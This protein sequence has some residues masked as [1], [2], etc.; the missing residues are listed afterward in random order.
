[1]HPSWGYRLLERW[2]DQE[3]ALAHSAH[4]TR[5]TR[6]RL[7]PGPH[8][9]TELTTDLADETD[10]L[11]GP[12]IEIPADASSAFI[13]VAAW[14]VRR[15]AELAV[16]PGAVFRMRE[17]RDA[18]ARV[19][20][21]S[22]PRRADLD[23]A[24]TLARPEDADAIVR[25]ELA[26]LIWLGVLGADDVE[27]IRR[28]GLHAVDELVAIA[29]HLRNTANSPTRTTDR[30]ITHPNPR[31]ATPLPD[32]ARERAGWL[33]AT[34]P[35]L[36]P[37]VADIRRDPHRLAEALDALAAADDLGQ[38]LDDLRE[39]CATTDQPASTDQHHMSR[40]GS[41][42]DSIGLTFSRS[43]ILS[44]WSRTF[45]Y[46]RVPSA[47]EVPVFTCALLLRLLGPSEMLST[48]GRFL[49]GE[50]AIEQVMEPFAEARSV[51]EALAAD[52]QASDETP[53]WQR[54]SSPPRPPLDWTKVVTRYW[55]GSPEHR[56]PARAESEKCGLYVL[57]RLAV[58]WTSDFDHFGLNDQMAGRAQANA[59]HLML[60]FSA[61]S[62]IAAQLVDDPGA[63][64]PLRLWVDE[65]TK[66][67]LDLHPSRRMGDG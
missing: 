19:A 36:F 10:H 54:P 25:P 40:A 60:W 27:V 56:T 26:G 63:A 3:H 58:T 23:V 17:E 8:A 45:A 7:V 41:A 14:S 5:G 50:I 13:Q 43:S 30:P 55:T 38:A 28:E 44:F 35:F 21:L 9:T 48:I 16:G 64:A 39:Q 61:P 4:G 47:L 66:F 32:W 46:R 62:R 57:D 24:T 51:V 37:S 11:P 65:V 52:E 22:E 67:L 31:G 12:S 34:I 49:N 29:H 6:I 18:F 20:R 59:H 33:E 42:A 2:R 53:R 15:G 1:M